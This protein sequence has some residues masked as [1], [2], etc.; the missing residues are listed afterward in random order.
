MAEGRGYARIGHVTQFWG[1]CCR[2]CRGAC[3]A[4]IQETVLGMGCKFL[5]FASDGV[6]EF[7]SSQEAVDIGA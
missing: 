1:R 6:W 7:I 2:N 4:E 5:I 3:S